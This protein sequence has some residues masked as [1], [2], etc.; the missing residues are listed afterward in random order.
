[1]GV[2]GAR[3]KVNDSKT[4]RRLRHTVGRV[5]TRGGLQS[6]VAD[7]TK[8]PGFVHV[9][10]MLFPLQCGLKSQPQA[11]AG[12]D[13]EVDKQWTSKA[14]VDDAMLFL[15]RK[16]GR[17][18]P[19]QPPGMISTSK[20]GQALPSARSF[21]RR[22]TAAEPP[23]CSRTFSTEQRSD[24][25][26]RSRKWA[27]ERRWGYFAEMICGSSHPTDREGRASVP[28]TS[29]PAFVQCGK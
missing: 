17:G 8:C 15:S 21:A 9:S 26:R 19:A 5:S 14:C 1:M 11:E 7:F 20:S 10:A 12:C 24:G 25:M 16:V 29:S 18:F 2:T 22:P 28:G 3:L 6:A 27:A 13:L 23:C 4:E